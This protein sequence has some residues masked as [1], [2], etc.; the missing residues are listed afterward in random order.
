M[1]RRLLLLP[2]MLAST[3][4]AGDTAHLRVLFT[5][6]VHAHVLPY[7]QVR[8]RPTKGSLAQVATFVARARAEVGACVVLDGGDAIEGTPLAHYAHVGANADGADATIAAMNLIGYDAVTLGNHEFNYGLD[9]LRSC[10]RQSH[11]PWLAANL[12]GAKEAGLPLRASVVVERGGL[13]VGVLGLTNPNIPHWDPPSHWAGLEFTDPVA[14]ARSGVAE[15]RR[16]ADVVI[17]VIHA[18]F[19]QDLETGASND[20]DFENY[21]WRV[22]QVPGID[23]LLTGHTHK[24]IPPRR[25]GSTVIAQPG[26]WAEEVTRIDLTLKRKGSAWTVA[27]WQGANVPVASEAPD[28]AIVAA[29]EPLRARVE[30]ELSRVIGELQAPLRVSGVPTADDAG[31]DLVH[32][33]QLEATG[34]QLSLAA[35]LGFASQEFP[36][37]PITPRLAHALYPYPN[38][39]LVVALTGKQLKEVLEHA[40]RGWVGLDCLKPESCTLLRDPK[41][42]AY[43]FDS[44]QGAS[45][46]VDP[47][48][49]VGERIHG[50]RVGGRAVTPGELFTVAINSYRGAGGGNYPHLAS[51][52]RVKEVDRPMTDLLI[53]YFERHGQIRPS[54]DDNW[55]LTIKLG[56][57]VA[58]PVAVRQ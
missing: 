39:L 46:L 17:V 42:P 51:A 2:L 20:T 26:R 58:P 5:S 30:K 22:A 1:P 9:V 23:V 56:E 15:L 24:D 4:L 14:A 3:A 6:D 40:A 53:E 49:P 18:G 35:P 11:V 36:A 13:R 44:L 41:L 33:V 55:A 34:A 29:T 16:K 8:Q 48:A 7:D 25:L 19:E 10:L 45:Y 52:P 38:T 28:P 54:V 57:R 47:L 21:A 50:L 27:D 12:R 43:N 37:G 31:L 32:A